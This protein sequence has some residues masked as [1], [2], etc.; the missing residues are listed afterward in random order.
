MFAK[1]Q[2]GIYHID[3]SYWQSIHFVGYN[4]LY[5]KAFDFGVGLTGYT[6]GNDKF[7]FT[8]D[9]KEYIIWMWKGDYINLGA[10]AEVGIYKESIVPGHY[11]T[12]DENSMPMSL[13]LQQIDTGKVLFDYHPT[14]KQWWIN[15]FD[16]STQ[17]VLKKNLQLT[18]TIDFS[19]NQDLFYAFKQADDSKKWIFNGMQAM[20]VWRK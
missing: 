18:V 13:K 17:R 11:L 20:Y 5:D 15:G 10:G 1:D 12:S 16:P 9:G 6:V 4:D 2:D 7:S 19:K 8:Y 14:E 3:Q